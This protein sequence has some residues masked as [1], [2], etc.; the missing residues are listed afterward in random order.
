MSFENRL[1]HSE[2]TGASNKEAA[3]AWFEQ[4]KGLVLSSPEGDTQP[5]VLLTDS[6]EWGVASQDAWEAINEL[7]DWMCEHNCVLSA[8]VFSNKIQHYSA[9]Q[10]LN[11]QQILRFFFDYDEAYQACISALSKARGK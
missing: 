9:D 10:G 3:Q 6:R 2:I 7:T 8:V 1:L 4:M 11:E 5:W